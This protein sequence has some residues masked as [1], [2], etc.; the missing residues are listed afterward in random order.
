MF[1]ACRVCDELGCVLHCHWCGLVGSHSEEC[2]ETVRV[3][4][5]VSTDGQLVCLGCR[6]LFEVG[7]AYTYIEGA[8]TD[9]MEV[10]VLACL[11]CAAGDA[12][13]IGPVR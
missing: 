5:V 3:Y 10:W 6:A 11:G 9:E 13:G 4:P 7:D 12:L 2:P 8:S 1:G